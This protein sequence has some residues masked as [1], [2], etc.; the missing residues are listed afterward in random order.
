MTPADLRTIEAAKSGIIV[1]R[2]MCR[3]WGLH[4][5]VDR[6]TEILVDLEKILD[7]RK[8]KLKTA[9]GGP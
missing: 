4:I 3:R 5:G 1:L 2:N 7:R 6:A 9:R 8:A